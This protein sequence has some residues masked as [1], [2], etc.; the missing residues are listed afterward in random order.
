LA[1]L[2]WLVVH[3]WYL[4]GFR[5]RLIVMIN[6]AF[7]YLTNKRGARLITGL[8]HPPIPAR[9][10]FPVTGIVDNGALR[11]VQRGEAPQVARPVR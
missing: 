10:S 8:H 11:R 3:I 7:A 4:I 5:N 2:A 9:F 6:W 1:W